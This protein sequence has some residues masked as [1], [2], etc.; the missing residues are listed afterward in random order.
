MALIQALVTALVALIIT[1][2]YLFYFDVTPKVVVLLAGTAL[3]LL[4]R[5]DFR[6][7][8]RPFVVLL[9]LSLVS[10]AVS[11]AFSLNPALS[12]FGTNWRRFG[13]VIQAAI[14]LFAWMMAS[15]TAGR[16]KRARVILR[17]VIAAGALTALYGIAQ[18]FG[19]DPLLPAAAYHVG[20]GIWTIVRP[21]GTLGYVSYFA[22][23][24]LFVSFLG[25]VLLT[26]ETHRLWRALTWA[27]IAASVVAIF[28][29]GTR[30]AMLGLLTGLACWLYQRGFRVPRRVVAVAAL[31][32][33]A[34]AAFYFS[35]PGRQLRSRSRWFAE[36]PWGG[37]RLA[38]WRDS[39]RMGLHRLPAGYGPEVFTAA[40]PAFESKSAA[41]AYPDFSYES[42]HNMFL[43]ALVS[44]GLLGLLILIGFCAVAWKSDRRFW[45]A[46]AAAIVAQQFTVFIVPTA[47][48]FY[49]AIALAV[50]LSCAEPPPP[51]RGM[52]YLAF[53]APAALALLY[54]A[55]RFTVSDRALAASRRDLQSANLPAAVAQYNRY[56]RWRLPGTAADLWY[57]R[58][59]FAL[60]IKT[61][62]PVVRL[63]EIAQSGA[64]A[65]RATRSAEDP[66]NAWYNMAI[67]Y[68]N[69]N[70][71]ARTEQSLRSAIAASPNWFKPHWTLAQV[72]RLEGRMDDAE[73]EARHAVELNGGRNPEVARTLAE[74]RAGR[75]AVNAETQK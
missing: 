26:L 29:T 32:L 59:L 6:L 7:S 70:D 49:I 31:F 47:L 68:A 51:R 56:Q 67:L 12:A 60:A 63:Q 42:P 27:A 53:A 14:L 24:L 39:F 18:Y 43:D 61:S 21:P 9:A 75:A 52:S 72:L 33:I 8:Y 36:D 28:L 20:E 35:P 2:E 30:A 13:S 50:G 62:N 10:L 15:H 65:V 3:A 19:W 41:V 11:T 74:I 40:F 57:S 71:P 23:W 55:A 37:A 16:P 4:W 48:M 54:I 25:P 58:T 45:P 1:P 69:Q 34:G 22:T 66:F 44:Q 73:S 38:L 17:G 5:P 64:A 46:V